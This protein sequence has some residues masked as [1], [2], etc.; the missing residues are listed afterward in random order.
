M[1]S[2][3]PTKIQIHR[4]VFQ[5]HPS[6]F[7]HQYLP[8]LH[9]PLK[10]HPRYCLSHQNEIPHLLRRLVECSNT[11][12][13]L[14]Q[15]G[16]HDKCFHEGISYRLMAKQETQGNYSC[17]NYFIF[18]FWNFQ[19]QLKENL[20]NPIFDTFSRTSAQYLLLRRIKTLT[21]QLYCAYPDILFQPIN[22]SHR[23][24]VQ[25][26][27]RRNVKK[28]LSIFDLQKIVISWTM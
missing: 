3:K 10:Y 15:M 18:D 17:G 20:P 11:L 8:L 4:I 26:F 19:Y 13:F 28:I 21:K 5:I 23:N 16:S 12:R 27:L 22:V 25:Y 6:H 14:R 1:L 9:D 2:I 7:L 24:E